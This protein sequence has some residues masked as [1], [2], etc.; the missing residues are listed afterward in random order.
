MAICMISTHFRWSG[1]G[2]WAFWKNT[3]KL[4]LLLYYLMA[5]QV[6]NITFKFFGTTLNLKRIRYLLTKTN[7]LRRHTSRTG[8]NMRNLFAKHIAS[9]YSEPSKI[10]INLFLLLLLSFIIA[11]RLAPQPSC[12]HIT[13]V[14]PLPW[15]GIYQ[16]WGKYLGKLWDDI[17]L[18]NM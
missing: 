11:V 13:A 5:R 1:L 10:L 2:L 6:I 18:I 14:L 9:V 17:K 4:M 7:V 12:Y 8:C 16:N 15:R 3:L